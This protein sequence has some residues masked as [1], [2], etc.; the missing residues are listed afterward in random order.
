MIST[1]S[2]AARRFL[3]YV[4]QDYSFAVL[5]P[6]QAVARAAGHEVRWLL[7]E[8]ASA[9]LLEPDEQTLA[10]IR[11]AVAF[12][13]DAVFAPGDRVP[14]FL[15]GLKVQVFHGIN[16]D[17]RGGRYPERGLF[18]L[19]CTRNPAET[20]LLQ[21]LAE[22]RGYFRAVETGW[23][24][25]DSLLNYPV[26]AGT[27]NRPQILFASTFTPRLS[28]AEDLYP[29][30]QRL[31]QHS[32]WQWLITLHPKMAPAT[33]AK[34]QALAN[35]NLSFFGTEHVIEL[36]HRADVM[37]SDNSSVLQ[38][39]LIL[40]KP[41]VTFNNRAPLDCMLNITEPAQLQPAIERALAPGAALQA[42]IRAYGPAITPHLDG[43]SAKRVL[44]AVIAMLDGGWRDRKP[45]NILRNLRM[46]HQLH[47]YRL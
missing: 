18:D 40:K 1:P 15:P 44:K 12:A 30:I 35:A 3:F 6:L 22:Q 31:S 17:K 9:S 2:S 47:Y 38:E 27:Y 23:L 8:N 32:T 25:L 11:A 37:V 16:E 26:R 13:P 5:R 7:L 29:E 24:K 4:E 36:L 21:P 19:Y 10:D 28:A 20:D 42:A 41:V 43:T 39:F 46:R 33:V 14:G 34:Y 45:K